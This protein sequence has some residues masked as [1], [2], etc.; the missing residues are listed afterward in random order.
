MLLAICAILLGLAILVWSADYFVEGAAS[1]AEHWQVPSFLIGMIIIG[2]GTSAPELLVS[3]ISAIDGNPGLALGNAY[4]SNIA[5]IALVIGLTALIK[6]IQVPKRVVKVDL[7]VLLVITLLSVFLLKDGFI[8]RQDAWIFLL[9]FFGIMGFSCWS[10]AQHSTS[11]SSETLSVSDTAL[12]PKQAYFQLLVGFICLVA[13]ARVLVWGSVEMASLL[14]VSDLIIGLTIVAIGTSLPELAT[15]LAAIRRNEHA[16]ALGNAM[17]SNVFNTLAVVG[18]AGA[19]H[20]LE[21]EKVVLSRDMLIMGL[22]TLALFAYSFALPRNRE[23]TWCPESGKP[24]L[25]NG[26][27]NRWE[28]ASLLTV[29]IG[30]LTWLV[31]VAL[32]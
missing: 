19:I 10:A 29:Y 23:G 18:I 1:V 8:S 30:Y 9:V 5:N 15:S 17:G 31:V 14:G 7:P 32:G 21:V 6:P 22:V 13:S 4:G 3:A 28:G 27:I 11:S 16:L 24:L 20:P 2:F 12:Q 26:R 25:I